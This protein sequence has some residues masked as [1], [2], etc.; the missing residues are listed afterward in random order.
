MV[1]DGG[2]NLGSVIVQELNIVQFFECFG[3]FPIR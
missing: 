1:E 3:G 2:C